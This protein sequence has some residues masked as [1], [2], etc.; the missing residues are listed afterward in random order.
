MTDWAAWAGGYA[1][2]ASSHARRLP[3]V[4]KLIMRAVAEHPS[5]D[6]RV[7]S[8]CAGDGR[9]VLP[10]ARECGKRLHGRLVELTP[11]LADTARS[12]AEEHGLEFEVMCA[13]AGRSEAYA[14]DLV[15]LCGIFG[16]VADRDVR[17]TVGAAAAL[18]N[19]DG[20][21]VWTRHRFAPDLTPSIREWFAEAGFEELA[22]ESPG[23]DDFAVGLHRRAEPLFTF[24]R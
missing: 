12:Y 6:L 18:C 2:P 22:F 4:Q 19:V 20:F 14:A 16:N 24:T 1:D 21:V 15:L 13:D 10:V 3:V 5:D 23:P 11:Q 8:L 7:L 17:R 9:D